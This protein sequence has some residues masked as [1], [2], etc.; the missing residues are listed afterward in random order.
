MS[1]VRHSPWLAVLG[2]MVA[3]PAAADELPRVK[4][5][6]LQ[7]APAKPGPPPRRVYVLHSGVHTILANPNKNIFAETMRDSLKKRGIR[8][9]D[10]VVLDTPYPAA[11]WLNMF[12]HECLTMFMASARPDSK[13]AHDAYLRMHKALKKHEVTS[14]DELIWIGHSAGGQMGLTMAYL[15][16]HHAEF[17]ALT[18]TTQPYRFDMVVT[19]G[20]PIASNHV[21][22]T[23]KVRHYLSPR[24][25]VP[26]RLMRL[27]PPLLWMMRYDMPIKIVSDELSGNCK[28]RLFVDV[29]HPNWDVEDR[30]VDRILAESRPH[31]CP[32]WQYGICCTCPRLAALGVLCHFLDERCHITIEDS[33]RPQK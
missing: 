15:A 11:G 28:V 21:P 17:T 30:V 29:E 22:Q 14:D 4:S 5:G 1:Q 25:S 2:L 24:D 33:P 13:V 8:E 19:L 32:C 27:S 23:V 6:R 26:R 20:S 7:E 9:R 18:K 12:P 16:C 10:L 3:V 31:Y